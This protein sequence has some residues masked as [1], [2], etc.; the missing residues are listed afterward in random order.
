MND[1]IYYH[2]SGSLFTSFDLT[3]AL[4]GDGKMKF[5]YGVYV[6]SAYPSAA[7]YSAA[8]DEWS[9]HYV[10]TIAVPAKTDDNYIA[11]KKPVSHAIIARAESALQTTFPAKATADGKDFRKFLAKHFAPKDVSDKKAATI[12]GERLASLF[13]VSIGVEFIEWPYN[14]KNPEAGQNRAILDDKKVKI[15]Q[16][17]AIELD[18]KK[19]LIPDSVQKI[20]L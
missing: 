20:E 4:E 1:E 19:N 11:F 18:H 6:T 13:L 12:E 5:G 10:F 14:W 15:L 7:R 16:V 17:D 3:H 2:G 8:N 9:K